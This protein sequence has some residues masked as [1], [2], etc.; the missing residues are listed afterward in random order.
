MSNAAKKFF[1][2]E[3]VARM[4]PHSTLGTSLAGP[5]ILKKFIDIP[6]T[7]QGT[8]T[9]FNIGFTVKDENEKIK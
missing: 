2:W 5:Y 1:R 3:Q 9:R 4:A 7:R 6:S 8:E